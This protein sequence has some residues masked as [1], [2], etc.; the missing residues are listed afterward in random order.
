MD[1][2]YKHKNSIILKDNT[3][4]FWAKDCLHKQSTGRGCSFYSGGEILRK[5]FSCDIPSATE[6]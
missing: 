5:T 2:N 3:R 4:Y 6:K 1:K